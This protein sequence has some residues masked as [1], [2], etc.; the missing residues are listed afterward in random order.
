[1]RT[2]AIL[3][4]TAGAGVTT[5]TALAF[6]RTRH[7][8]NGSPLLCGPAH[9]PLLNRANGDEVTAL[10]PHIALWD[11][12]VRSTTEILDLLTTRN[13]I[14]AIAVPATP[15]GSADAARVTAAISSTNPELLERV[16]IVHTGIYGYRRPRRTRM[17]IASLAL[18]YDR[19][20]T[21][22]GG[23]PVDP[24]NYS[25]RTRT[26]I[27]AWQNYASWALRT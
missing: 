19:A 22:P 4:T 5:L 6:A 18:P 13:V 14:V 11:A 26:A 23:V 15:L 20:L 24:R 27:T 12:G 17:G 16:T 25:R 10:N 9:G 8:L 2:L 3:S 1:M 7:D 21:Q